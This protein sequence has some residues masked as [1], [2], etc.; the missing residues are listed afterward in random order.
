[1]IV[2]QSIIRILLGI[3][4]VITLANFV[5]CSNRKIPRLKYGDKIKV[6]K[7][8]Y[9][10]CKGKVFDVRYI[11]EYHIWFS[12]RQ[13]KCPEQAWISRYNLGRLK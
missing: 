12:S 6:V 4:F 9:K 10:G 11:N 13:P 7:G 1:M 3:A 2:I 8:F 5:G